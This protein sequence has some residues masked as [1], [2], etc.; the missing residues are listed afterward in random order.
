MNCQ[1]YQDS[2]VVALV[3]RVPLPGDHGVSC[4]E[5]G[6]FAEQARAAWELA[7]RL[8]DEPVPPAL[9]ETSL[10]SCR[11][12][13]RADLTLLRPGPFAAAAILVV[14]L[15]LLLWPVKAS[16]EG[17][18]FY[19]A[20]DMSV[21]RYDLPSGVAADRVAKEIRSGIAPESWE[22]G[23]SQLEVGGGWIRIQAPAEVH[24]K[25]REFLRRYR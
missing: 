1:E 18:S 3:E 15:F 19:E 14:G 4:A 22:E 8:P 20:G 25:V 16:R 9:L 24:R 6:R 13:R 11:R 21:E 12:A 23:T 5:C 10:R 7:G 17:G 2:V